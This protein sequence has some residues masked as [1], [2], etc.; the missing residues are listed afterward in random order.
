VSPDDALSPDDLSPDDARSPDDPREGD[1]AAD[2]NVRAQAQADA[3]L[4][5]EA[6]PGASVPVEAAASAAAPAPT[7]ESAAEP[8]ASRS[9]SHRSGLFPRFG[10]ARSSHPTSPGT[11]TA[12]GA[13]SHN[14]PT[15][16]SP[17]ANGNP[18]SSASAPAVYGA[19]P[20]PAPTWQHG[21]NWFGSSVRNQTPEQLA[22]EQQ[23]F[24]AAP[25]QLYSTREGGSIG[26]NADSAASEST[27]D[28][29]PFEARPS[30]LSP[31]RNTHPHD[32][33]EASQAVN[34][35]APNELKDESANNPDIES[36]NPDDDD[37]PM[38]LLD[39]MMRTE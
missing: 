26:P 16:G 38:S 13:A 29:R 28:E 1:P 7:A 2:S 33:D 22:A 11:P 25:V 20:G 27:S 24:A 21:S 12:N 36:D 14:A 35:S 39:E 34:E 9:D 32:R 4:A 3:A 5:D 18:P 6:H 30:E 37:E 10:F 15:N 19:A 8:S 23:A 31:D 17:T